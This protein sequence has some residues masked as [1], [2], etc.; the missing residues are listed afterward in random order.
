VTVCFTEAV[1]KP[2][3]ASI[4]RLPTVTP[5]GAVTG[6]YRP[7]AAGHQWP[8]SGIQSRRTGSGDD[9]RFANNTIFDEIE[10]LD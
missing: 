3:P 5:D 4:G 10:S 9:S 7:E 2:P 8:L 1:Q 6:R